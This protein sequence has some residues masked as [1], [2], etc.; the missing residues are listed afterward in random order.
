MTSKLK[1]RWL[2]VSMIWVLVLALTGWNIHLV[3]Q[4]QNGRR[5]MEPCRWTCGF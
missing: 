2:A 1:Y 5:N 4:I 3:D